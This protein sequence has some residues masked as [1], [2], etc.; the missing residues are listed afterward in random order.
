M[1]EILGLAVTG[2]SQDQYL[3]FVGIPKPPVSLL[4]RR[5]PRQ[6]SGSGQRAFFLASWSTRRHAGSSGRRTPSARRSHRL[7][8]V[9]LG[10]KEKKCSQHGAQAMQLYCR[11]R[12]AQPRFTPFPRPFDPSHAEN[13]ADPSP[14]FP[15]PGTSRPW[16]RRA[17]PGPTSSRT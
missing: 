7:E 5:I 4:S 11:L 15:S 1:F 12:T 16:A 3:G 2:T 14:P 13:L 8:R 9:L 17:T 10:G 6:R